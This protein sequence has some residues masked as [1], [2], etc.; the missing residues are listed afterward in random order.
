MRIYPK[1]AENYSDTFTTL[2]IHVT[3]VSSKWIPGHGL[4]GASV[5]HATYRSALCSRAPESHL[6][7]PEATE[8]N[9]RSGRRAAT[10]L[11]SAYCMHSSCARLL[12]RVLL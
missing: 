9:S 11:V 7:T 3:T 8:R 2:L 6:P 5:H 12:R 10:S 4:L 1:A